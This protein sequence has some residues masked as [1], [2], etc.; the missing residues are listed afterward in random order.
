MNDTIEVRQFRL[1][2]VCYGKFDDVV[3]FFTFRASSKWLNFFVSL[4]RLI[5]IHRQ[6]R[7]TIQGFDS[8]SLR[9]FWQREEQKGCVG[10]CDGEDGG[11]DGG[12]FRVKTSDKM[13][14]MVR[15]FPAPPREDLI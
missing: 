6:I 10:K 9:R 2:I 5:S 13:A 12:F 7:E 3:N 11:V 8:I 1:L 4:A 14:V 15:W